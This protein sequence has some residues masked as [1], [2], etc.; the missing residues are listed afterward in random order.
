M[1][2]L[3]ILVGAD[4][5]PDLNSGAA[6]T[7]IE[8]NRALESLGQNVQAFWSDALGRRIRHGNLHYLFEL[9][10]SYRK[11]VQQRLERRHF[12][13]VQLSQPFSWLA[14]R[15]V[16]MRPDAPI[17]VWRSHGLEAKVDDAIARHVAQPGAWRSP[18]RKVVAKGLRHAQRQAAKWNDGV[19]VPCADDK[20]YL[21]DHFGARDERVRVVWH[22]VPDDYLDRAP[23]GQAA[24]WQRI[25]HVS[26]LSANKGGAQMREVA[27]R[28][29]EANPAVSMT[30][31]CPA[32]RHAAILE[33]LPEAIGDRLQLR[34]WGDRE[35][36]LELYDSHGIFLFPTLAEGAAKVVMEAMARGMCVVSSD[37]SGPSDYI[38]SGV[39]GI[40]VPVG[41]VAPMAEAAQSLAAN[42]EACLRMG[43]AARRTAQ[44]F[45]WSRCAAE[46][47][48]FYSDLRRLRAAAGK[49]IG[50]LP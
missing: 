20:Q 19:V 16:R 14:A 34:D 44:R 10:R 30:W 50:G 29:L 40:L 39:N 2:A 25:L 48:D 41:T 9:P 47:L 24:R 42:P 26:Q 12:D 5:N 49:R 38:D 18:L 27:R 35:A 13:V 1:S 7:V 32:P 8:T 31:V 17:M 36:L 4:V 22:G 21:L 11:V 15:S 3:D 46:L 23:A 33:G 6:G 37:T 45:R 43:E 28:L